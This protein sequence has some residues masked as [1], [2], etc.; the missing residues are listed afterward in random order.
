MCVVHHA[1]IELSEEE[2]EVDMNSLEES[3]RFDADKLGVDTILLVRTCIIG[4]VSIA[5]EFVCLVAPSYVTGEFLGENPRTNF[6]R[7][8]MKQKVKRTA[9]LSRRFLIF[10]VIVTTFFNDF[11]VVYDQNFICCII[12]ESCYSLERAFLSII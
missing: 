1:S 4:T 11:P 10:F 5:F 3:M 2:A 9:N 7:T 12:Y 8:S 6:N